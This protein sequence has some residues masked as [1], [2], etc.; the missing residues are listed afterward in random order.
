MSAIK[1]QLAR[2]MYWENMYWENKEIPPKSHKVLKIRFH[3]EYQTLWKQG[4]KAL[5]DILKSFSTTEALKKEW[6]ED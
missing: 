5:L 6:R 2:I 1:Q 4:W 3:N